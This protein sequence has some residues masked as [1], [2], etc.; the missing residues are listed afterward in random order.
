MHSSG[1]VARRK[2]W[3]RR[4]CR[5][6]LDNPMNRGGDP[7]AQGAALP[8]STGVGAGRPA[9]Q[10]ITSVLIR[11]GTSPTGTTAETFMLA[12]SMAVT[13]R[14]PELEM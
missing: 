12:V 3:R 9:P 10:F 1:V 8:S 11:L 5:K 6:S 7:E 14:R 13:E 2:A 4:H